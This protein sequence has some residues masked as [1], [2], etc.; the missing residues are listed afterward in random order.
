MSQALKPQT[1]ES[2]LRIAGKE[3]Q[4]RQAQYAAGIRR[5]DWHHWAR[6]EQL[7][8]GSPG[9][10]NPRIDWRY[11]FVMAGRGFGKTRCGAETIRDQVRA[12]RRRRIALIAPTI[13]DAR[14]LM[15]EGP[16][17]LLNITPPA[18][19]PRWISWKREL[20]WPNGAMAFVYTSKE[21]ERLRGNE[22]D[23][24]WLEEVGAWSRPETTWSN[25]RLGLRLPCP[26]GDHPQ[27]IITSTP[28]PTALIRRLVANPH[29]VITSGTTYDNKANIDPDFIEAVEDEYK[30]TRLGEQ[31]LGGKLLTDTPG[32]LWKMSTIES[33]RVERMPEDVLR[34]VVAID[35]AVADVQS[36][37]DAEENERTTAETGIVVAARARCFCRGKDE[38]HAFLL[39]DLSGYFTPDD[40]GKLAVDAYESRSADRIV[41]EVNNGGSLVESVIRTVSRNVSYKAVHAS[42]GK[43]MR[44]EPIAALY[45]QGKVHH[46]GVFAKLEDQMCA[47]NPL[48]SVG[49]VDRIDASVW[50]MTDLMLGPQAP[51]YTK[52][53]VHTPRRI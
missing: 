22:H 11:W 10:S 27:V 46:V 37:R 44:A 5:Y 31:E 50:A 35:P 51:R 49:K 24:A 14:K 30:G 23:F 43:Q 8:P 3:L 16:S 47:W 7:A 17:G 9:S 39:D 21:P 40:W 42:R 26:R 13:D 38:Q 1:L 12:G 33:L 52:Q 34:V 36:R 28:R 2:F 45:D 41:A 53:T 32:A 15:I 20:H 6:P 4:I 25:M 19:R 48:L 29:T 18:E